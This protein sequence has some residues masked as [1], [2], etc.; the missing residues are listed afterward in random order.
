MA[1]LGV[2][3][4]ALALGGLLGMELQRRRGPAAP[5]APPGTPPRRPVPRPLAGPSPAESPAIVAPKSLPERPVAEAEDERRLHPRLVVDEPM[6]VTPF[7]GR[8][9]M[10]EVCDVSLGGMRFRVVGLEVRPGDLMRVSFNVGGDSVTAVARILR[11]KPLDDIT[12]EVSAE[13]ARV[14]P[15]AARRLEDVLDGRS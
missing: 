6:L 13:F 2:F 8:E 15:W 14:D 9:T 11:T 1:W 5:A 10:G 4:V 3:L 12:T 7:A